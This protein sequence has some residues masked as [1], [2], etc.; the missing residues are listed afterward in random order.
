MKFRLFGVATDAQKIAEPLKCRRFAQQRL[1]N[2]KE[3]IPKDLQPLLPHT[4]LA[5]SR[6][7]Y[8]PHGVQIGKPGNN[9]TEVAENDIASWFLSVFQKVA[10]I[11]RNLESNLTK[12]L[13]IQP[14]FHSWSGI[15]VLE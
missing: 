14:K 8:L 11:E 4:D 10:L 12:T 3:T 5:Q 2:H 6:N 1:L 7:L 15:R 13:Q 9:C